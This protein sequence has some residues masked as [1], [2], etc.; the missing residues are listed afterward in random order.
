V[1]ASVAVAEAEE[2]LEE[3]GAADSNDYSIRLIIKGEVHK[4]SP[5]FYSLSLFSDESLLRSLE[6]SKNLAVSLECE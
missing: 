3:S 6:I 2:I 1:V 4:A 5:F